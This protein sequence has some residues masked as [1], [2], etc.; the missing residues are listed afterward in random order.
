MAKSLGILLAFIIFSTCKTTAQENLQDAYN[1]FKQNAYA[2]YE[3]FRKQVNQDYAEWMKKAW[4]WF[5]KIDPI[6]KPKDDMLP[7]VIYKEEKT[8]IPKPQPYEE[9]IPIPEPKPQPKPI[10][11]IRED[12]GE[13]E[14]VT[15]QFFGTPGEVRLPQNFRLKMDGCDEIACSKAWEQLSNKEYN[16]L[17]R[18]CL[19]LRMKHQLCDWAYLLMLGIL[20]ETVCGEGTN[21]AIMMQAYVFCQSGYQIRL[22]MTENGALK[23]LFKSDHR[24]FDMTG[25]DME[26]GR[27][28]SLQSID[29]KGLNVYNN[30]FPKE[31]ALSLW[32][33]QVPLLSENN[34]VER[35][36]TSTN[37]QVSVRIH[38]NKNL[39]QFY[40]TYPTSM[41]GMDFMTRWAMYANTPL[42]GQTKE[43][44]YSQLNKLIAKAENKIKAANLILNWIQTA[45]VY[46][47][48]NKV[49]GGD[50]AFFAEETLYYPYCDCEDR[51][52]LFSRLI[53][54]LLGFEVVLVYY[55]GHLA[56]AVA[57]T[58][59]VN[60]DYIKLG[61]KI[62]TICDPTF[63]GAP[64]GSTMPNMD[65]ET[66][67]I[68][69]LK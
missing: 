38:T 13:Y 22:G 27:Y 49:W 8:T 64:I 10:T 43:K 65:N 20:S 63:I 12:K 52:I 59:P 48:D 30:S 66:A 56:T 32:I 9:I 62:F 18:D 16:N 42:S 40:N 36:L 69:L 68:I 26:D 28:Y 46:E 54:D 45:F 7:P 44:L 33:N 25:F 21:E 15:F 2:E 23:L 41:T 11:P 29:G 37:Q 53:R 58:T 3:E 14:T 51:S 34:S 57:F 19:L 31:K 47:Y 55:P 5:Q 61:D 6:P 4:K 50:R 1:S 17:I 67:K 35:Q 39:I 60:G 24:I